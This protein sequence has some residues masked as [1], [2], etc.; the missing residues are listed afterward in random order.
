MD[1]ELSR[2][3]RNG[4]FTANSFDG[5]FRLELAAVLFSTSLQLCLFLAGAILEAKNYLSQWPIFLGP[6]QTSLQIKRRWELS[7]EEKHKVS[8]D[9]QKSE[10]GFQDL[11]SSNE[12]SASLSI[13]H[14]SEP[15]IISALLG[16]EPDDF[17]RKGD[18]L[19]PESV[20]WDARASCTVWRLSSKGKVKDNFIETHLKWLLTTISGKSPQFKFLQKSGGKVQIVIHA[21]SWTRTQGLSLSTDMMLMMA[22]YGIPLR[23]NVVYRNTDEDY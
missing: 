8:L 15:E 17:D 10:R 4:L 19:T 18:S 3:L 23:F 12:V 20:R 2:Q 7:E 14:E 21:D 22:R 1:L 11:Q 5:D 6:P 9:L 13:W 16:I